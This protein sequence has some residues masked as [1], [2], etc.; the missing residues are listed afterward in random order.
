MLKNTE[1]WNQRSHMKDIC[2]NQLHSLQSKNTE[3]P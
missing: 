2:E 1:I 3:L